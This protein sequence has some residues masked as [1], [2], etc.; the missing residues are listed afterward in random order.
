MEQA[1]T[2]PTEREVPPN[3]A[4]ADSKDIRVRVLGSKKS[5]ARILP[6]RTFL[7]YFL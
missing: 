4:I 1:S 5:V 3:R 6:Y 2:L 7:S